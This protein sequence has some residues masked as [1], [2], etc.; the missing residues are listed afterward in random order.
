MRPFRVE[1]GQG[2]RSHLP[3]HR[4]ARASGRPLSRSWR[5]SGNLSDGE[6]RPLPL[7]PSRIHLAQSRFVTLKGAERREMRLRR[8][9]HGATRRAS[10]SRWS[11]PSTASSSTRMLDALP[12]LVDYPY[13]CTEQT[14][15]R[16]VSTGMLVE[17][18]R[19][20]PG[21]GARWRSEMAERDTPLRALR[22]RPIPNRQMALEE[23]PWLARGARRRR[24]RPTRRSCASSTRRSRAPS[25]TTR[26]PSSRKAQLPIGGFPWF[27]GR[28]GLALHHALSHGRPGARRR[29][30]RRGAAARWCSA[31][32]S[33]SPARRRRSG[34]RKRSKDDCCWELLT[35]LNYVASSYPDPS[36][37]GDFLTRGRP[38]DDPRLLLQAL[39]RAPA[40]AQ[41]PAGADARSA[42]TG[43]R[44]RELVLASVMD[45]AK[46]T[47]DEGTF[48]QP[49]DRAWLWYNDRIETHAWALRTL[50]EV[51][52]GRSAP[53]RARAVALPQQE[54]QPLEVDAR[55]RRGALLAGGLSEGDGSARRARGGDGRGG[56]PDDDRSSSS[57]TASPAR[58]TRSSCRG[59]SSMRRSVRRT[60][61]SSSRRRHRG[62]L[63]ASA[64]WHF[65]TEELPAESRSDLFGVERRYFKR[66]KSGSEVT[67]VPI[68]AEARR[69]PSATRSRCS[70]R[71]AR[72]RRPSTST[73]AIRVR[74]GSSPIGRSRAGS[75]ISA[76]SRYEETRDSGANFFFENLPAGEYTF[77]YRLR[78][79]LAGEFRSGPAQVQSIY[80]PE[81]VAYSA[82]E[83][84][85][86][87][88]APR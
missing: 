67:L 19:P 81:F 8:H 60:R 32:G 66:V 17:P 54:A 23:T 84:L 5:E 50:M 38:A 77:K 6:L 76:S 65:S 53:R 3:A 59:R 61:R 71:C 21:G 85:R 22:R 2:R 80:A 18:L 27:A 44:T 56:E 68:T 31:A 35:Y 25:A 40:A 12:Y 28:T 43:T 20:V 88:A 75:G 10:T 47:R 37:T 30:R 63:F 62:S 7:L 41:A 73:C 16:F 4:A 45:S 24:G 52:P 36:W 55:H 51:A 9:A 49:E 34:C 1:P 58:R 78:A 74:P 72:R 70:S 83:K 87:D 69:S 11:S 14:L 15:N 42:W 64:T 48:W 82:G 13:E 86:I 39:A 46:T 29:V 57:P 79:N 33:T 26:S